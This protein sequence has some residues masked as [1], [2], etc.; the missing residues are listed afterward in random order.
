MKRNDFMRRLEELLEQPANSLSG[1]E[2]LEALN[3]DSLKALEFLAMVDETFGGEE[4]SPVELVEVRL[5]DDLIVTLG[6]R[7][8]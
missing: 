6:A 1:S 7:I 2:E 4:L 5:V 3:W 8:T